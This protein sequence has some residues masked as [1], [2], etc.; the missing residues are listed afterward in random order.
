M[1]GYYLIIVLLLGTGTLLNRNRV[2]RI[3]LLAVFLAVQ[4]A[5]AIYGYLHLN[6][7]ELGGMLDWQ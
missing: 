1:F 4:T 6:T 5:I 3:L 2:I 7:G